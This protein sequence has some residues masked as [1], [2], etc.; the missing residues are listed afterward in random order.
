MKEIEIQLVLINDFGEFRGKKA[1]LNEEQYKNVLKMAKEFHMNS[2]FELTL[3]DGTFVIFPA[4]V[5]QKS[6][7]KVTNKII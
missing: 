6:I 1:I 3:E 4:D 7:L 5:V 2:G